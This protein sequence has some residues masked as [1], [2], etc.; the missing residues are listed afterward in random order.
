MWFAARA[1]VLSLLALPTI[2]C[3]AS[4]QEPTQPLPAQAPPAAASQAAA[5]PAAACACPPKMSGN[6][7]HAAARRI[8]ST[9]GATTSP[10]IRPAG[11]ARARAPA[12]ALAPWGRSRAATAKTVWSTSAATS[13][14]GRAL[15]PTAPTRCS[16]FAAAAGATAWARSSG[17]VAPAASSR[18]IAADS[19]AC[20][21]SAHPALRPGDPGW[22][23]ALGRAEAALERVEDKMGRAEDRGGPS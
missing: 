21:V 9:P 11:R 20:G 13:S 7:R 14:S 8:A 2:A 19:G 3:G 10:R 5:P 18:R 16:S 15:R 17:M 22:R 23:S 12:K 4:P 6:G 1:F